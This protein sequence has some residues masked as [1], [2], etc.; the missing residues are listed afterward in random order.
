MAGR[1]SP[2]ALALVGTMVAA[3]VPV[4]CTADLPLVD[5]PDHL[6]RMHVL[7]GLDR[8]PVLARYYTVVWSLLPNLAMDLVVPPLM[9]LVDV[10][11]A[12]RIF[13][14][15]TMLALAGGV[16][17][18][19]WARHRRLNPFQL[20][21]FPLLYNYAFLQGLTNYL[22]GIAVA[23]WGIA[24]WIR[25][26]EGTPWR[27][28]AVSAA[29]AVTV[30]FCH[31][32]AAGL[33]GLGLLCLELARWV[34][35]RRLAT[36]EMAA[37][38]VPFLLL[39]PPMLV[40]PTGGLAG[41]TVFDLGDK[42]EG[43]QWL[44]T[45]YSETWD[46]AW[47]AL[48][49]LVVVAAMVRRALTVEIEGWAVL[50]LGAVVYMAMPNVLLGSWGADVRLPV[51]LAFLALPFFRFEGARPMVFVAAVVALSLVR[52]TTM[53][54]AWREIEANIKDFRQAMEKIDVGGR[55]LVIESDRPTGTFTTN[56]PLS[57][58]A[59]LAMIHRSA[60]VADAFTE[61]GKQILA[62]R[63][64]YLAQSNAQ[65]DDQPT[66]SETMAVLDHPESAKGLYWALWWRRFDY[67]V[68]L[69][70]DGR[71]EPPPPHLSPI[72]D[73]R[74]FEVYKVG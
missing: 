73:G 35:H 34:R 22:A 2:L 74:R 26:R 64:D 45:G 59:C 49:G 10:Y 24:A 61:P 60:F 16:V 57:H 29:F 53:D 12:G 4:L 25:L 72:Y 56:K 66:V 15:A 63:P 28:G 3:M 62:V 38:G 71:L 33:Y 6:A 9:R 50:G 51:G 37:F 70:T 54:L 27:R 17:A 67:I 31:L 11:T 21:V 39:V 69:Y 8:D 40:S 13:V 30:F 48:V 52:F 46:N 23:L 20:L 5:Y 43:L 7:A 19:H 44:F 68:V 14:L 55:I 18:I 58:M 42:I 47:A 1:P 32:S 41:D 65:D 36:P